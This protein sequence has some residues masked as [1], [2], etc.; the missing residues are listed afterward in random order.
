MGAP[1]RLEMKKIKK[2]EERD[3]VEQDKFARVFGLPP[4]KPEKKRV[5]KKAVVKKAKATSTPTSAIKVVD[6]VPYGGRDMREETG[7]MASAR[8]GSA[9]EPGHGG[10]VAGPGDNFL[11]EEE[12]VGLARA[13]VTDA[14]EC[15]E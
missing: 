3:C 2:K 14:R 9:G 1:A 15:L 11:E 8:G 5:V 7:G 13:A 12:Q 4:P 10:M 6:G